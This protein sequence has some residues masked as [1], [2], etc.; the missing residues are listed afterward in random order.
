MISS[1]K[2]KYNVHEARRQPED[3]RA[4]SMGWRRPDICLGLFEG[5]ALN[6]LKL[7]PCNPLVIVLVQ[8]FQHV[9]KI[10]DTAFLIEPLLSGQGAITVEIK[11]GEKALFRRR[12][13]TP[14][15]PVRYFDT[16]CT[17]SRVVGGI[18][19]GVRPKVPSW[20][21]SGIRLACRS[22]GDQ[23]KKQQKYS[24][25]HGDQ[26]LCLGMDPVALQEIGSSDNQQPGSV[27]EMQMLRA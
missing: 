17:C 24:R 23:A 1:G 7:L 20:N 16:Y 2:K 11:H 3:V 21:A 18:D 8:V 12:V 5:H 27:D 6:C 10:P 14:F 26:T 25:H 15:E 22:S 4:A 13:H 9:G 19:F